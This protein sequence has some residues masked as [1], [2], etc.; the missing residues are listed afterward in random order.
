MY[1]DAKYFRSPIQPSASL[2][3]SPFLSMK[4]LF[5]SLWLLLVV[6]RFF[7]NF[8]LFCDVDLPSTPSSTLFRVS[9]LCSYPGP[10]DQ[11]PASYSAYQ[12]IH[13]SIDPSIFGKMILLRPS[14]NTGCMETSY[15]KSTMEKLYWMKI[16]R[17]KPWIVLVYRM[18]NIIK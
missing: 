4:T 13:P 17:Q 15:G 5:L 16:F 11:Q 1:C 9:P 6:S 12:S 14:K 2:S 8:H 3:F 18:Q 7:S 10:R